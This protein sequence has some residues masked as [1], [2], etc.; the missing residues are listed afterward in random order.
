LLNFHYQELAIDTSFEIL[1]QCAFEEEEK[2]EPEPNE[3]TMAVLK[4]TKGP[5][6]IEAGIKVFEEIDWQQQQ[7][8]SNNKGIMSI[9]AFY[10]EILKK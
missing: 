3:K 2:P 10:E 1:K 9:L 4:S 5:G 6:L 8:T 7:A